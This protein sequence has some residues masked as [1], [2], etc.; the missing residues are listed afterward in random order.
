MHDCPRDVA[1]WA[2]R[3][4][5]G[6][7]GTARTY[8]YLTLARG[9]ILDRVRP[10]SVEQYNREFSIGVGTLAENADAHHDQRVVLRATDVEGCVPPYAEWPIQYEKPPGFAVLEAAW[11]EQAGRTRAALGEDRDW[12]AEMEYRVTLDDGQRVSVTMTA[13][14]LFTQLALHEVHHRAQAMNMLRQLGV[15]AED[16]DFNALMYKRR[17]VS[18]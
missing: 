16:L 5:N 12:D 14:D 7:H 2:G 11:I 1:A 18:E 6:R 15:A 10:L 8:D 13:A 4:F 17:P 3:R 9:R